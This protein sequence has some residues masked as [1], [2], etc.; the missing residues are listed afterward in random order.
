MQSVFPSAEALAAVKKFGAV[1]GGRQ[2]LARLAGHLPHLADGSADDAMVLTRLFDAP[3][4]MVFAAWSSADMVS[5]WWGPKGFTTPVCELDFRPGGAYRMAMRGPDGKEYPFHGR[6]LEIVPNERIVFDA[7]IEHIN[8]ETIIKVTFVEDGGQTRVTIW[9]Q[10]APGDAGSGQT[11][12]WS[13][14]LGK[15]ADLLEA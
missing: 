3:P 12:G 7:L 13:G 5:K 11:E 2:T 14:Q 6:Y 9:Q 8:H 1:E 4:A 10:V 15:L